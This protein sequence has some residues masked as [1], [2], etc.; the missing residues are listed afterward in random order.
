MSRVLWLGLLALII[1]ACTSQP[2]SPPPG[3][4]IISGTVRIAS[5]N[6]LSAS[7][8]TA[9]FVEGE[10]IVQFKPQVGLQ[11]LNRLS[12]GGVEL[13]QV[14]P[15]G[16]E[17][18]FL[19]RANLNRSETLALLQQLQGQSDVA[20][21]H[22]NYLL[23]A[24]A[25]PNDP[26]YSKQRWHYEAIRLPEAWDI[27]KGTSSPVTVAVIDGGVPT[28][29]P[30]FAGK[31][32]SGYDFYSDAATSGDGDG[33]D[34][35]PEDTAPN[36]DYHGSHVTGTV[37]AATNN[38]LGVAGV[39]WGARVVPIRALSGGSGTLADVA[40]ALHWAAGLRVNGVPDN[41][42]PAKVINMSLGAP[43]A[44][45]SAPA[46]Q[47]AINEASAAG[48]VIVVAAGNSNAD[49]STFTPAGC[50]GVITVGATD[51]SGNRAFYSNYGT[52]I[53]V[54]APGGDT[55]NNPS[56]GV[57]STINSNN[58]GFKQGTSMAAPHVAGVLAL[59]KSRKP[60][61]TPGEALTILKQTARPLSDAQCNRSSGNDCGAGLIDAKAALDRLSAPPAPAL[62]LTAAPASLSLNPGGNAT[63]NIGVNRSNFSGPVTLTLSGQP[64]GVTGSFSPNP[65]EANSALSLSVGSGVGPGSYTLVI[66][67][68]GGEASAE[69][70]II[71]T[72]TEPQAP[73]PPT[74]SLEGTLLTL[75]GVSGDTI[76]CAEE[77]TITQN[78]LSSPFNFSNLPA[79]RQYKLQGWKDVNGNGNTDA[80]D[81][82]AWYTESGNVALLNV[83]RSGLQLRLEPYVSPQPL[84]RPAQ[85]FPPCR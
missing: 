51:R 65:T 7:D 30:D 26:E 14:R 20:Y 54:M 35:N 52:R 11:S 6:T 13:Q 63:I 58:Y 16:L 36:T 48:A 27:E 72:V 31:L 2:P 4:G 29:H 47:Q 75:F 64:S 42:N 84:L 79:D 1:T 82:F 56:N 85:I 19:Y 33:R 81:L 77:I 50:S 24:Q 44:C 76:L 71:L 18:T 59:M 10:I 17:R 62:S 53:D 66:G 70:R 67:G 49:A 39:S 41:S 5:Q 15:L 23:F 28:D 61:L 74:A 9:P 57:L 46:L 40:D 43:V 32:L 3:N 22:P 37:A 8:L 25:I 80:G 78:V 45:T 12:V 55:R 83:G 38:N 69:T 73:P 34:P 68:S 21:A 60:S